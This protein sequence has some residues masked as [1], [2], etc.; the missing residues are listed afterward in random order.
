[1]TSFLG[2]SYFLFENSLYRA[3]HS[4]LSKKKLKK[5]EINRL[6]QVDNLNQI[7]VFNKLSQPLRK[8][9]CNCGL[10]MCLSKGTFYQNSFECICN[11]TD[12]NVDNDDDPYEKETTN[13][14]LKY[15]F[16]IDKM[17]FFLLLAP[18][19]IV[20]VFALVIFPNLNQIRSRVRMLINRNKKQTMIYTCKFS[21]YSS[22]KE[23]LHDNH[24]NHDSSAD[25]IALGNDI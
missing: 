19:I 3:N 1:M 6:I 5:T 4:T 22:D 20:V 10:C 16:K 14:S 15:T 2:A 11:K 18:T 23:I 9:I 25:E 7:R 24:E 21:K 13:D 8:T 17:R 12:T